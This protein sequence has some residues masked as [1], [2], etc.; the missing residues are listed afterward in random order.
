MAYVTN[1]EGLPL[2]ER[3]DIACDGCGRKYDSLLISAKRA[4]RRRGAHWCMS[5]VAKANPKPQNTKGFWTEQKR[6][7]HGAIVRGSES[8]HKAIACRD[9]RGTK[10]GMFGKQHSAATKQKMSKARTGKTGPNATAWKGGKLSIVCRVKGILHTRLNWYAR[11]Y[12]RDGWKCTECS[13]TK[14]IDAHHKKP[15]VELVSELTVGKT[16]DSDESKI[17]W[18]VSQREIADPNLENG[19]TL[20]RVCHKKVHKCWGSHSQP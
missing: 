19:V 16:F 4:F 15:I 3:V 2:Y 1:V 13:S 8:Y 17:E 6:K 7:S 12:Q 10:N 9:Q 11:V 18:L 20:C 14:R 5:C